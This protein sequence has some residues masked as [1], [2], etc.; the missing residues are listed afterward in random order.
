MYT[1]YS[2]IMSMYHDRVYFPLVETNSKKA[3]SSFCT[4]R[5]PLNRPWCCKLMIGN[6]TFSSHVATHFESL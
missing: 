6:D 5:I 3:S 4:P 1:S 2:H